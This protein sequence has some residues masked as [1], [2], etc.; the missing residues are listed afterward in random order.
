VVKCVASISNTRRGEGEG[1]GGGGEREKE[2]LCYSTD[3]IRSEIIAGWWCMDTFNL[4]TCRNRKISEF[5]ASRVY[6]ASSRTARLYIETLSQNKQS[7]SP[8]MISILL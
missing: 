5:E 6:R 1:K 2:A 3:N 8:S 4:S 7:I